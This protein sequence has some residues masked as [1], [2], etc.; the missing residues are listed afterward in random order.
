M[1]FLTQRLDRAK[2]LAGLL[3]P[4]FVTIQ[5][6]PTAN[7]Q[8]AITIPNTGTTNFRD[9]AS[10]EVRNAISNQTS[11]SAIIVPATLEV[12]KSADRQAA[13]PG[14]P[15]VYRLLIRN[16]GQSSVTNLSVADT[17]PLGARFVSK[18][19]KGSLTD[20]N[21]V[22]AQVQL[23]EATVAERTVTFTY[24]AELGPRQ[25][26]E[27]VYAVTLTPDAIRGN[28]RNIATATGNSGGRQIASNTASNRVQIRSGILSDCG[29]LIGRVFVDRNFDGEQ[30]PGEPGVPNAVIYLDDGNRITTDP[31]G[32]F[33]VSN[34]ISGYRSGT[35]DLTSIPGYTL[36]PNLYNIE[37]NSQ[38][39]LVRLAPGGMGRMNFAVTPS[40]GEAQSPQ[41]TPANR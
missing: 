12:I 15:V 36:A 5:A 11:V 37:K 16:T 23:P 28:G 4:G 9:D 1:K 18:S 41:P 30:Q 6:L 33:S 10:Q 3:L 39:R 38:S 40:F 34:V 29:T 24:P 7:A 14:D 21:N 8:T 20:S 2:W 17:L 22:N 31:N 27:I 35:L 19:L 32:L 26:L 25:T 13:E